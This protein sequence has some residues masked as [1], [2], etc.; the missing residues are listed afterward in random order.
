MLAQGPTSGDM[1]E[2]M[3]V[4]PVQRQLKYANGGAQFSS[5]KEEAA[6]VGL[7]PFSQWQHIHEA[8]HKC[9]CK[10]DSSILCK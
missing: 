10:V 7:S 4:Q 6:S 5:P 9:P 8:L 3:T 2:S 1:E